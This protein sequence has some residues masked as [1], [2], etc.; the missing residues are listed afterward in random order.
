MLTFFCRVSFGLYV[1]LGIV[2]G[3]TCAQ[4]FFLADTPE[5]IIT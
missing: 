2:S 4:M 3:Y 5:N 1:F